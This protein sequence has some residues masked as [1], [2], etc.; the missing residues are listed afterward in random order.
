MTEYDVALERLRAA[1]GPELDLRDPGRR[2]A[3]I[4]WLNDWGCR[5]LAVEHHEMTSEALLRW[6]EGNA[7]L[8]PPLEAP[9]SA[10]DAGQLKD[11]ARAF[12]A[13]SQQPASIQQ[14]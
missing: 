4:D 6:F 12:D 3:V 8:L 9:L 11:V 2:T 10:L 1:I 13:L 14:R 7:A 5:H